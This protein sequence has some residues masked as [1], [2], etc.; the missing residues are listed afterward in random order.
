MMRTAVVAL[1]VTVGILGGFYGGYRIGQ[2]NASA[3]TTQTPAQRQGGFPGGT[4]NCSTASPTGTPQQGR[5]RGTAGT[6]TALDNGRLTVRDR[7][8]TEV[9]VTFDPN[10]PV[11]KT[12]AGQPGDLQENQNVTVQ[13]QMQ[14]DGSLRASA[15]TI[16][17]AGANFGA[18]SPR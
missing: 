10:V 5:G 13:G 1:I 3:A 14:P 9:K 7:C 11:R 4:A 18:P 8:G 16:V 15:I 12:V 6:V 2:R 17:P